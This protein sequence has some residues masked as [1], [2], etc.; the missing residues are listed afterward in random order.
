M[1]NNQELINRLQRK[2]D[3]LKKKQRGMSQN[4]NAREKMQQELLI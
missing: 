4:N 1:E 3:I 2:I